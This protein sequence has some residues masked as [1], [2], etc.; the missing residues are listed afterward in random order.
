MVDPRLA[1]LLSPSSNFDAGL[2]ALAELSSQLVA[3]GAPRLTPTPPP[4]NLGRV[5]QACDQSIQNDLQRGL[6]L[7]QFERSEEDY[8]RKQEER[9]AISKMLAPVMRP[10]T[11]NVLTDVDQDGADIIEQRT[12]MQQTPSALMQTLPPALRP[13][14]AALDK[15]GQGPAAISAILAAAVKPQTGSSLMKEAQLLYPND[16]A[17]QKAFIETS[18]SRAPLSIEMKNNPANIVATVAGKGFD[19]AMEQVGTAGQKLFQLNEMQN[20]INSGVPTGKVADAT[21]GVR[22]ILSDFG[23]D[24]P[25]VPIQTAI[26]SLGRELAL[27]KHGPGMGP[28]TN[29]DFV[30]YQ[31]IVPK[32]GNTVGGNNLLIKRL[33]REYLGQQLYAKVL[34]RQLLSPAGAAAYDPAAA[35]REVAA[36]LDRQVGPLVP[37]FASQ[38]DFDKVK[39]Q[40]VGQIVSIN[41][42]VGEVRP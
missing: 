18:R 25:N 16:P 28:M 21:H 22:K 36:E 9:D 14:V 29:E 35:W 8:A 26:R 2:R 31:S 12:T 32:M 11:E 7:R 24:D 34:Q 13:A 23:Y 19:A 4:M 33:K 10:V 27:S 39:N 1:G 40:Y 6:A 38:V 37:K 30:I 42:V 41:G 17:A 5:M 3:R 20:L 15:A